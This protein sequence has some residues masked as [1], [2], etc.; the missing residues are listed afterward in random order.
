LAAQHG[1][2]GVLELLLH[3]GED[4][5][6]YNPPGTHSHSTPLHQA[7]LRGDARVTRMLVEHGAGLD[8]LD[9]M[10]QTTPEG[11][12]AY[13]GHTEVQDYLRAARAGRIRGELET[14]RKAG[15]D[16]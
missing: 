10:F 4:P 9:L 3:A 15:P 12:A 11:W 1:S 7:A 5:N 16:I 2:A 8:T 14:G 6:R 13:A